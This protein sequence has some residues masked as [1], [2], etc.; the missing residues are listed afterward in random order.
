MDK[1]QEQL[2]V[3][4]GELTLTKHVCKDDWEAWIN[5]RVVVHISCRQQAEQTM[6]HK[7]SMFLNSKDNC[8]SEAVENQKLVHHRINWKMQGFFSKVQ[9]KELR[10]MLWTLSNERGVEENKPVWRFIGNKG[11]VT[12]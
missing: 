8:I 12:N 1:S 9:E 5:L 6:R 2:R 7:H 4:S 10:H 3:K 11:V